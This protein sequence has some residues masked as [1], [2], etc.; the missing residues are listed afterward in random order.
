MKFYV[1][2]KIKPHGDK[3][4]Y[5]N[6]WR[7]V[8]VYMYFSLERKITYFFRKRGSYVKTNLKKIL[9]KIYTNYKHVQYLKYQ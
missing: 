9:N 7:G 8:T 4:T 1:L 3:V 6:C 5:E 2:L